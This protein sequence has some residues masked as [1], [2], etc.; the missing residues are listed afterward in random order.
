LNR[1]LYSL[2]PNTLGV[3][4]ARLGSRVGMFGSTSFSWAGLGRRPNSAIPETALGGGT[5]ILLAIDDSPGCA[6]VLR[7]VLES[8]PERATEVKVLHVIQ[9]PSTSVKFAVAAAGQVV[10]YPASL[11]P[12]LEDASKCT[13]QFVANAVRELRSAGLK[14]AGAVEYGDPKAV[15]IDAAAEW[16]ADLIVLGARGYR[17]VERFLMGSVS[18]AVARH[19]AC[20]VEIVRLRKQP[21]K[22]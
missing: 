10:G 8:A 14:A 19:A 15:I 3:G 21:A 1:W 22:G 4:I 13:Q 9:P 18:E 6:A 16:H 17:G 7:A 2:Q 20:S 5:R 12:E 11:A